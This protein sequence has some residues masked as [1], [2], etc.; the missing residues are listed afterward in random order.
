MSKQVKKRGRP[1]LPKGQRKSLQYQRIA[2]RSTTH[3]R[4]VKN[5][6]K[7]KLPIVDYL[8]ETIE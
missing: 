6:K 2:V 3:K 1:T 7:A 5:A 8:E 4:I